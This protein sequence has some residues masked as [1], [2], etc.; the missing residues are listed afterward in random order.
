M[1]GDWASVVGWRLAWLVEVQ[2]WYL[3]PETRQCDWAR[4]ARHERKNTNIRSRWSNRPVRRR[5]RGCGRRGRRVGGGE[6]VKSGE[7]PSMSGWDLGGRVQPAAEWSEGGFRRRRTGQRWGQWCALHC[8]SSPELASTA[9]PVA[10]CRAACAKHGQ[11][12]TTPNS[13]NSPN[14]VPTA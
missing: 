5:G 12:P 8:A 9:Q 1:D 2:R 10:G 7:R 4:A 3:S 13:S 6:A 11:L 14:S